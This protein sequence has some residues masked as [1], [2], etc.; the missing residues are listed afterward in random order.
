MHVR[1]GRREVCIA[2]AVIALA[3]VPA[4][5]P[6]QGIQ[7]LTLEEASRLAL[8]SAEAIRIRELAVQKARLAVAEATGRAWPHVDLLVSG[9]YLVN[10]PTGYTVKAGALGAIVIPAPFNIH[11]PMPQN[12]FTIGAQLHD[13]FSVSASLSQPL[14]TWGKIRNAIDAAGLQVEA[15]GTEL[16]RQRRDIERDVRRAYHSALLA[17][18]SEKVL[19]RIAESSALIVS[20]RRTALDQGSLTREA[21]LEAQAHSAR[22]EARLAEAVQSRATA[23]ENLGV[24]TGLDPSGITLASA[25][26][27]N[28]PALDE[29]SLRSEA[30]E[31]SVDIAASR[32]RQ[33]QARKK[34][35]IEK[36]GSMLRP[37]VSLGVSLSVT[38]QEDI[39]YSS[40]RWDASTWNWD[41]VISLGVKMSVFDGMESAARIGQAE[42]DTEMAGQALQQ[43][44]KLTRLAV[45]S[46][47]EAAMRAD[48]ELADKQAQEAWAA[49]R[50]R[51]AQVSVDNGMAS[52]EDLYG[53][54]ILLGTAQLDRLLAQFQREET[55]A[56]IARLTGEPR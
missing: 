15:A 52:R 21:V 10:P 8:S 49:E 56:D 12:D 42:K 26:S 7:G 33:G 45:R 16:V 9:S 18:E 40:W 30:V 46:A 35:E 41:L 25:F 29:Q 36:G 34:L 37:D 43:A 47:V 24:L 54:Q 11:T 27:D 23:L 2:L 31:T 39:P 48:A 28:L 14:F 3:A 32:N 38:G 17:G 4:A 13:Y 51:N 22:I 1:G 20:D 19:R 55:R 5:L 6:A 53:A 44:E 50:L